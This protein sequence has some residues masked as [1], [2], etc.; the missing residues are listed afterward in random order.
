MSQKINL[1]TILCHLVSDD[2]FLSTIVEKDQNVNCDT[3]QTKKNKF[4]LMADMVTE[5][6]PLSP[7][8]IQA[9]ASFPSKVKSFLSPDY[10]RC[11]IKNIMEK[12]LT[13]INISF[14]S[15]FN[16]LL[17]PDLYRNN[18]EDH[19]KNLNLLETFVIQKIE[20]NYQIDKIKNTK[21]IKEFNK[22]L[23]KNLSEGKISHNLIN[24]IINIFEINLLIFDFTK[25]DIYF[26]WTYG[27]K[28]PYLNLFKD[29]YCMA[30]IHGN[31]EPI[32]SLNKN[33]SR[34]QI[35]KMYTK[36]LTNPKDIICMPEI[37]LSVL[38]IL[39]IGTWDI[40]TSQYNNILQNFFNKE[41]FDPK[42]W[43]SI[44]F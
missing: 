9:Y 40:S 11:G 33:I 41:K 5:Y 12:N 38:S 22:G 20:R 43:L 36:I 29:L 24:F 44:K 30:L 37:K 3:K 18:I 27:Y 14:L 39:L 35:Q 4:N 7:Y 8:E 6:I 21:K 1:H 13:A 19:I 2:N 15:S 16:M 34:E 26:Y 32:M 42:K 31:Y 23:I 28:Y 17:R 10:S 25:M